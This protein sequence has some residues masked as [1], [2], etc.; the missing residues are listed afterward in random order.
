MKDL[1]GAKLQIV[2][3]DGHVVEE[4]ISNGE[5]HIVKGL[6][7]NKKYIL[8]EVQ[9]PDGYKI[10]QDLPFTMVDGDHLTIVNEKEPVVPTSDATQISVYALLLGIGL[11][12]ILLIFISKKVKGRE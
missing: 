1:K 11:F 7:L 8:R 5:V 12:G 10:S 3:E 4:W 9:A 6:I 2:D